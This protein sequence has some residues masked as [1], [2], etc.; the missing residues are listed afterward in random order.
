MPGEKR[1]RGRFAP[2]P[3]GR[4][5]LGNLF[6]ALLA[7][8]DVRSLGGEM[9]LRM[10]D[11]DPQRCRPEY[12]RQLA[13][14]LRW[15]GLDWDLGWQEGDTAFCQSSRDGYYREA[16]DKLSEKR[17][18]YPCYCSR[19]ELL[20]ASAPH[21]SD[22]A[23]VYDGHCRDLSPGQRAEL[24]RSGRSPAWRVRV[25]AAELSFR[26]EV[27][28]PQRQRLDRDC[29]DFILRRSDGVYAYQLAVAED[30]GRMGITRVVRG[31]DLLSSTPRQIWLLE[32]LG[33]EIPT[34]CHVPL[35]RSEDGRR[36]SKR[37][38]DLD[39]GVLRSR[40][41]PEALTG[42]LACLAGLLDRP[43]AVR[44]RDLIPLFSWEKVGRADRVLRGLSVPGGEIGWTSSPAGT[45][46]PD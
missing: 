10:E 16:L 30:D 35:L 45:P 15:L 38:R 11:L 4:M 41:T 9:V 3:S 34:Y 6:A 7:W 33:Y 26:D 31:W 39:M 21:A 17:L 8:L 2:S 14:D 44:P 19:K 42:G 28:G 1:V 23:R 32:Q 46:G 27:F 12:S 37:D 36:L 24:E 29:G 5:H 40:F 18:L 25:P 43:E 22:G 13:D 20:A